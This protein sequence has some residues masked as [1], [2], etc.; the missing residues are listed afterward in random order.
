MWLMTLP[1]SVVC[2]LQRQNDRRRQ[3][4]NKWRETE[5]QTYRRN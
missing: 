4:K 3:R 2:T 1:V 5:R